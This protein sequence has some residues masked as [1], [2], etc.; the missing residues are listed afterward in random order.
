MI[1]NVKRGTHDKQKTGT[2]TVTKTGTSL[3]NKNT[4]FERVTKNFTEC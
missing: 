1:G 3:Q 2:S 4:Q